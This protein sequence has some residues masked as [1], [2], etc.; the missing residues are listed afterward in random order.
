MAL[1]GPTM[2]TTEDRESKVPRAC[3]TSGAG[4]RFTLL[5]SREREIVL[6]ISRGLSN[7]EI[8]DT[9]SIT[10]G[11]V[12]LHVHHILTKLGVRN[13]VQAVMVLFDVGCI[14]AAQEAE[15]ESGAHD[16]VSPE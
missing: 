1:E 3:S 15:P 7:S 6:L 8:A 14:T 10:H 11:T 4:Q 9:L 16:A 12:K 13:R 2:G 5:T